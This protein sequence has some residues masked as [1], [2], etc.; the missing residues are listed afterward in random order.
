M[1]ENVTYK[2][3]AF[4]T[5]ITPDYIPYAL[6]LRKSLLQFGDDV[7]LYILVCD[8]NENQCKAIQENY[9]GIFTL[10]TNEVCSAG[11][12]KAIYDKYFNSDIDAFRWSMKPAFLNYLLREK[13]VDKVIYADW[14]IHFYNDYHF[15]FDELDIHDVLLTPHWRSSDPYKDAPNFGILYTSGLYNGGFIGANKNAI[16]AMEWWAMACEYICIKDTTTGHF[17]DQTHLNILPIYF[18][19]VGILKHRGCNVANWNMV[20]CKRTISSGT[21]NVMIAGKY[22]LVFIHFTKSTI[23]GILSGTDSLLLPYL[24]IYRSAVDFFFKELHYPQAEPV[25]ISSPDKENIAKQRVTGLTRIKN[26][27]NKVFN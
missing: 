1:I 24:E 25:V 7:K 18:E 20:E 14:D 3:S 22:P 27:L 12:G 19:K 23:N 15:L 2:N 10:Y 6:V 13:N 9:P 4:C 11:I 21:T 26:L 16:P 8:A 17:V 5:I